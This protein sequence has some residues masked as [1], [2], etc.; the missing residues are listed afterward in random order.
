M[1]VIY[2]IHADIRTMQPIFI[3]RFPVLGLVRESKSFARSHFAAT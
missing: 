3:A 1:I 2:N